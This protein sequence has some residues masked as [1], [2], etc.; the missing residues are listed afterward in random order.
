MK[1][2]KKQLRKIILENLEKDLIEGYSGSGSFISRTYI[3]NAGYEF[4]VYGDGRIFLSGRNG[5]ER[6]EP[7]EFFGAQKIQVAQNLIR[8]EEAAGRRVGESSILRRIVSGD[9]E[10]QEST[11]AQANNSTEED[12]SSETGHVWLCNFP[13]TR[14]LSDAAKEALLSRIGQENTDRALSVINTLFPQGHGGVI[15]MK[16]SGSAVY[17]DFGRYEQ[18][19]G[20]GSEIELNFIDAIVSGIIDPTHAAFSVPGEVRK[21]SISPG[22]SK[23]SIK[24]AARVGGTSPQV[25]Y[26]G[27]ASDSN[28]EAAID[29][30]NDLYSERC[31]QYSL[32]PKTALGRAYNCGSFAITVGAIAKTGSPGGLASRLVQYTTRSEPGR[33]IPPAAEQLRRV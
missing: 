24:R 18:R 33:S 28:I 12:Y 4:K 7:K 15:L 9:F 21:R 32:V 30:A 17:Y 29:F 11:S 2:T 22:R 3:D 23:S 6:D 16:S 5:E 8:S 31:V 19:C 14:P 10:S 1:I 25:Y 13:N 27:P 20:K 26:A